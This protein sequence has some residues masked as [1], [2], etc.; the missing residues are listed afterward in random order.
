MWGTPTTGA[1]QVRRPVAGVMAAPARSRARAPQWLAPVQRTGQ[2]QPTRTPSDRRGS[3]M[4]RGRRTG[5]A[6][7]RPATA[8]YAVHRHVDRSKKSHMYRLRPFEPIESGVEAART[9]KDRTPWNRA[10]DH[11]VHSG[12]DLQWSMLTMVEDRP[13][14]SGAS[15]RGGPT[16]RTV[17]A[18]CRGPPPPHP[19]GPPPGQLAPAPPVSR[20]S[21]PRS[22][23]GRA[24]PAT[25]P[26]R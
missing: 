25:A 23:S 19:S 3:T 20:W 4:D 12:Q 13:L 17:R 2:V 9:V 16:G 11:T 22:P 18:R 5:R 24:V 14:D 15:R 26:I 10:R 1:A 21:R 8:R 7:V 6:G